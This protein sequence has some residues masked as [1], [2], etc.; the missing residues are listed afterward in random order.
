MDRAGGYD[1]AMMA[2]PDTAAAILEERAF[3][4]AS[5]TVYVT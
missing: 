1:D 2:H 5:T 3:D 4:P